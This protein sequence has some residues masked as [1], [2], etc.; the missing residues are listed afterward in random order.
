MRVHKEVGQTQVTDVD[1]VVVEPASPW[2]DV[3]NSSS[4]SQVLPYLH[5][6][7]GVRELEAAATMERCVRG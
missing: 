3:A 6:S 5:K 1:E 7:C 4:C 2:V